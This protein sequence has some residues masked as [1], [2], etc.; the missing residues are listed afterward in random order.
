MRSA[1]QDPERR[2]KLRSLYDRLPRF[3]IV[4]VFRHSNPFLL[5]NAVLRLLT[6]RPLN[7]KTLL[8]RV[9]DRAPCPATPPFPA[10]RAG[11]G[12]CRRVAAQVIMIMT[13]V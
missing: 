13:D 2:E 6:W 12:W 10:Q 1:M 11:P 5:M 9:R 8:Q 4:T 3:V 7:G